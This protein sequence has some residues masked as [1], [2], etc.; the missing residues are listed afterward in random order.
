MAQ[1]T[2]DIIIR[3]S[4]DSDLAYIQSLSPTLTKDID[5][6]WHSDAMIQKFQDDYINEMMA[7][8]DVKTITYIAEYNGKFAGFIHGREHSDDISGELCCTVPL[9]AVSEAAQGKG[10]GRKLMTAVESWAK[11]EGHR[12]MHLEVFSS[13]RLARG[14]YE[15]S[16]FSP[17]TINMIKPLV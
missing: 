1:H 9:L 6:H 7:K 8:T 13:N 3:L 4:Q 17:D 10:A 2:T 11:G 15:K 16:G 5:L 12:L 14:F